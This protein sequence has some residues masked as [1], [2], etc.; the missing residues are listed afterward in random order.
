MTSRHLTPVIVP[1]KNFTL[2]TSYLFP[3]KE[4]MKMGEKF[5]ELKITKCDYALR[6][7]ETP[8]VQTANPRRVEMNS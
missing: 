1:M 7:N 4:C 3:K 5:L 8:Q 6:S 2:R